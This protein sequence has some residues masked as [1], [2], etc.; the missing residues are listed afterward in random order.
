VKNVFRRNIQGSVCIYK[1]IVIK[2][3]SEVNTG[4]E[5]ST[6]DSSRLL[7][8]GRYAIMKAESEINFGGGSV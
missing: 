7:K 6:V 4:A 5:E 1:S 2:K 3:I 8:P